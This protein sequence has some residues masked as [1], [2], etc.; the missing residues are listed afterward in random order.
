MSGFGF[1]RAERGASGA[2]I[3]SAKSGRE[4]PRADVVL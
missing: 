4:A 3:K 1:Q 2:V